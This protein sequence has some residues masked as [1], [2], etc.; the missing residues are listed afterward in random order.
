MLHKIA[1]VSFKQP[2]LAHRF[3][4]VAL[5][6][7]APMSLGT[8]TLCL[9]Q[10]EEQGAVG[11]ADTYNRDVF[12]KLIRDQKIAEAAT[13]MD[14]ALAK[15]P[16][17]IELLRDNITV[18]SSLM[19]SDRNAAAE[20]T[21]TQLKKFSDADSLNPSQ[22]SIYLSTLSIYSV[23]ANDPAATLAQME[24]A[25]KKFQG[26]PLASSF[27]TMMVQSLVRGGQ[28]DEA[29]KELDELIAAADDDKAFL[30]VAT[31]YTQSLASHFP[32]ESSQIDT[33]AT[34]IAES[35]V[36]SE[37]ITK[38]DFDTYANF[39]QSR[40]SRLS[41]SNP[42]EAQKQLESLESNLERF[43]TANPTM[44]SEASLK[45]VSRS[46]ESLKRSITMELKRA[47][48]VGQPAK[49][50]GDFGDRNHFV[51]M[52]AKSLEEL[53]GKVI[54]L[55]FWAVWCGPCIATFP[56]LQE[57]HDAYSEKGLVIVGATRLYNY[58]WNAETGKAQRS[59]G[60]VSV[61]DE[62]RM[63]EKFRESYEL[64][65]GFVVTANEDAFGDYYAV[66][67]IPQAVVIDKK[68]AVRLVRVGSGEANAKDL[69]DMIEKLLAE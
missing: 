43:L 2:S 26:T 19:R 20:R 4:L 62:L 1:F 14:A 41:R 23:V 37:A 6:S 16:L 18:I 8:S 11:T 50:F 63:L 9:G 67:G 66:T 68:G 27:V 53:K 5:L 61:E 46:L 64:K 29:K 25:R 55:D 51:A 21:V 59:E 7:A 17:S 33:K 52:E 40:A 69:H 36:A 28:F 65:H 35:L 24:I 48:M 3:A 13:M 54:L 57:W 32:E 44:S 49:D 30:S 47:E 39:A 45:N 34:K 15:D 10:D 42:Q 38:P 56:H 22:A 58:D 31:I 12:M 60:Q